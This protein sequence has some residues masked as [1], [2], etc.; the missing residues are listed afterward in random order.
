MQEPVLFNRSVYQNIK[1]N[2]ENVTPD[3]VIKASEMAN[4]Y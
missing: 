1:Y 3:Q 4:A 2:M